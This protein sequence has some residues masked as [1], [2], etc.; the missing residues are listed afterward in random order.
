MP[1]TPALLH[2][3]GLSGS[4]QASGA[5]LWATDLQVLVLSHELGVVLLQRLVPLQE[6]QQSKLQLLVG[7]QAAHLRSM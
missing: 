7:L 6:M 3:S 4:L 1:C 5:Q 2:I